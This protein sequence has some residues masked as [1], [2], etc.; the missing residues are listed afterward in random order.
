MTIAF[1]FTNNIDLKF[2]EDWLNFTPNIDVQSSVC[3]YY[4]EPY[5]LLNSE[6]FFIEDHLFYKAYQAYRKGKLPDYDYLREWEQ[7]FGDW[8]LSQVANV[9]RYLAM[10]FKDNVLLSYKKRFSDEMIF[11]FLEFQIREIAKLFEIR[12]PSVLIYGGYDVGPGSALLV[13]LIARVKNVKILCP[14]HPRLISGTFL[15]NTIFN[16][17]DL[18]EE[19]TIEE[20][21]KNRAN[22]FV[23][24][25]QNG[26]NI[27]DYNN[28]FFTNKPSLIKRLNSIKEVLLAHY[29]TVFKNRRIY[30]WD[31]PI[32]LIYHE[33]FG[34]Y[35]K[36][37]KMAKF[38]DKVSDL[39]S[40]YF[41]LPLHIE[42]ELSTLL[43]SKEFS[44]QLDLVTLVSKSLPTGVKLF[45]KD[46]PAWLG[47]RSV[48]FYEHLNG[49]LNVQLIEPTMDSRTLIRKSLGVI[50]VT[51]TAA[52]EAGLIN[53]P[54]LIFGQAFFEP[55]L[56][57]V[58]K[59]NLGDNL[60]SIFGSWLQ[61][62]NPKDEDIKFLAHIFSLTEKLPE[63]GLRA[64]EYNRDFQSNPDPQ[65]VYAAAILRKI[66]LLK[67]A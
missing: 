11:L 40:S 41:Y 24:G 2:T 3:F 59:Y 20:K 17:W 57:S 14:Q 4:R 7:Y 48:F 29:G 52:F 46:H 12:K 34:K 18:T 39:N 45:V 28:E 22:E 49:L 43:Y 16:S 13:Y 35:S 19:A 38:F 42:P 32:N 61:K 55:Y 56:K 31:K 15:N 44:N 1:Y 47:R 9:Y 37:K 53:K 67:Q 62:D 23:I 30:I 36:S 8:T 21:Y 26:K 33:K 58:R 25:L 63:L 66:K 6:D 65:R 10:T 50:T 5:K 54:A 60:N 64:A 27:Y 51:G